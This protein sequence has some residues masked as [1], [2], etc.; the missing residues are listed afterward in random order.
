MTVKDLIADL[1]KH[2]EDMQVGIRNTESSGSPKYEVITSDL[3]IR[4]ILA[5]EKKVAWWQRSQTILVL[6]G[7]HYGTR[8]K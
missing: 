3:D 7:D 4:E 6:V 2:P 1:Q 5:E 8:P